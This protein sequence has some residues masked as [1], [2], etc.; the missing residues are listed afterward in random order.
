M[1]GDSLD[2]DMDLGTQAGMKT[3]LVLSGITS[4]ADLKR[5]ATKPDYVFAN[6]GQIDFG[7]LP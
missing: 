6:V 2:T 3:V 4:A 7:K 5:S 1:I